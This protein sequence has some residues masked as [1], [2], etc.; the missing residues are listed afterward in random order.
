MIKILLLASNSDRLY[1]LDLDKEV[2]AIS[3]KI[4]ASQHRD[5]LQLVSLWAVE[6]DDLLQALNEHKPQIVH[7][8]CH[9]SSEGK[10]KLIH[11]RT[12][13]SIDSDAFTALFTTLKD[14]IRVVVLNACYSQ[15]QAKAI[16]EVIDCAVG[17]NNI[18]TDKAA[19]TFISS[20]YRA[21]GFGRSVQEAFSQGRTSLLLEGIPENQ[22]P[23]LLVKEG[24]DPSKLFLIKPQHN[25]T[26][27][28]KSALL[29]YINSLKVYLSFPVTKIG[30]AFM[31]CVI[32][33]GVLLHKVALTPLS[34][35]KSEQS[36]ETEQ[37][38]EDDKNEHSLEIDEIKEILSSDEQ[39]QSFEFSNYNQGWGL[40]FKGIGRVTIIN[41]TLYGCINEITFRKR[42]GS[43]SDPQVKW[44][45]IGMVE[46]RVEGWHILRRS[47]PFEINKKFTQDDDRL[48]LYDKIFSISIKDIDIIDSWLIFIAVS[49][50]S[51][52]SYAHDR[53]IEFSQKS[54]EE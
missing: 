33:L 10:I 35:I 39:S 44:L 30:M 4:R 31:T 17:M 21:I 5:V 6:P 46:G 2:K 43:E 49:P 8:S 13:K 29:R 48:V 28:A 16:T 34:S 26:H 47:E 38:L 40:K 24:V 14:N 15:I 3:A 11:G 50:K 27:I 45:R 22:I 19:I 20:F 1:P 18:I 32:I 7:L 23:E 12:S 51:E 41:N 52:F 37:N 42:P 53:E 54:I 25:Y 9:G 36:L